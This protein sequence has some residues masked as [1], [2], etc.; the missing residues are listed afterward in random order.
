MRNS[1]CRR[2][3]RL[4]TGGAVFL[5]LFVSFLTLGIPAS[6]ALTLTPSVAY[7]VVRLEPG[8]D[9]KTLAARYHTSV[10]DILQDNQKDVPLRVGDTLVIREN[11]LAEQASRGSRSLWHWPV[12]GTVTQGYGWHEGDFHHGL[13]LGVPTGTPVRA[14]AAGK[15]VKASWFG[16]YGLVVVLDHGHGIETL[17][18]HNSRL[19]VRA[20]Q[21]VAPGEIIALAGST[22]RA[23]GPHL[24][25]EVRVD[26]Q[27]VEPLAY[28]P[29]LSIAAQ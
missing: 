21:T 16:V 6:A 22:G 20:G 11:T 2:R 18:A 17:Y 23:T 3:V 1:G 29:K 19:L 26:G 27:T 25:F 5:L 7:S 24:H 28:L 10:A 14:A 8:M 12:V 13:D 9:L 4:R 15:V